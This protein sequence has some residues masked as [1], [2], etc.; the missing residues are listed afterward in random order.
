MLRRSA[1]TPDITSTACTFDDVQVD[2]AAR[3]VTRGGVP[4]RLTPIEFRLLAHLVAHAGKVLTHRMLLREV[5]GPT[6]VE[7]VQYLRIYMA[8]LRQKLEDEPMRPR[9]FITEAG[10]GYRF[11]LPDK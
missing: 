2:L 5:W 3:T 11:V 4:V 9:H 10:V 8:R 1:H 6:H 7:D